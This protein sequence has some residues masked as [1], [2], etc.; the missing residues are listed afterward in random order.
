MCYSRVSGEQ[1]PQQI[2]AA[3]VELWSDLHSQLS[4]PGTSERKVRGQG[5][6]SHTEDINY[7]T[8]CSLAGTET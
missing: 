7:E 2:L 8:L 5:T 6:P 3:R 4:W 1:P